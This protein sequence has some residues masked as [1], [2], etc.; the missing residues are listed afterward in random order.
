MFSPQRS[1]SGPGGL[2]I[3]TGSAN[4]FN[5]NATKAPL[6][7]GLFGTTKPTNTFGSSTNATSA[8]QSGGLPGTSSI[9]GSQPQHQ[10]GISQGGSSIFGNQQQQQQQVGGALGGG[11][12]FGTGNQLQNQ[13]GGAPGGGS[14]F[15]TRNQQQQQ[16]NNSRGGATLF[17]TATQQSVAQPNG[18][19]LF[20]SVNPGQAQGHNNGL[21]QQAA[22]SLL[23]GINKPSIFGPTQSQYSGQQRPNLLSQ[24][25]NMST[26]QLQ[27]SIFSTSIGQ[28][29]Q[30]Q[31]TIPGV[32]INLSELRPTTRFNDLHDDIQK[33]IENVDNF[34]LNQIYLSEQCDGTMP[35]VE[36]AVAF[37]PNDVE[38]CARR[39]DTMQQALENDAGA[40]ETGRELVEKDAAHAR[41]SFK[42]IQNLR[43]P[44]QFQH[45]NL[46]NQPQPPQNIGSVLQ[47]G[48]IE[49]S[50]SADLVS[51]FSN[52]ADEMARTLGTFQ[53]HIAEVEIYLQG[54]EA[55]TVQQMQRLQFTKNRDGGQRSADDQVRELAA[56]LREFEGGILGVA[57]KVGGVREKVQ[58]AMLSEGTPRSRRR[59]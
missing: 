51:Y 13:G 33:I 29:S 43:M 17:G 27:K 19:P 59:G 16:G 5:I 28:Y 39:L 37:I 49:P 45:A 54:L 57:G 3:N 38:F 10:G 55:S 46:W 20:G 11:S 9:F 21:Q 18:P 47:D 35:K 4:A 41:L 31:Q 40:I 22:P 56:V 52:Q 14:I 6:S 34:I 58:E 15:G 7:G 8:P 26:S 36:S 23:G 1:Q 12:I 53:S 48:N 25:S 42:T 2:S 44:Q 30:A 24:S 32:R 50:G